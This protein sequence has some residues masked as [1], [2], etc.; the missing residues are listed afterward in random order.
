LIEVAPFRDELPI[1][2]SYSAL[3][4]EEK[5]IFKKVTGNLLTP[6]VEESDET[7]DV[8]TY[9]LVMTVKGMRHHY[10]ADIVAAADKVSATLKPFKKVCKLTFDQETAT[11]DRMIVEL[12]KD[13][14][15]QAVGRLGLTEWVNRIAEDNRQFA[16]LQLQRSAKSA[17]Q[18]EGN[19]K[20]IRGRVDLA[21]Y[22]LT[23]HINA[24][25]AVNGDA[26]YE[27]TVKL[28]N[29]RIN[30]YKRAISQRQAAAAARKKEQPS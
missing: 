30:S 22:E 14:I 10:D 27:E 2:A 29:E 25:M 3:H 16:E 15:A 19:M 8:H 11:L 1:F 24:L 21:Y 26:P 7:R 12:R 4:E 13:D 28:I 23:R 6:E 5:L 9:G 17:Q 18:L 20:S